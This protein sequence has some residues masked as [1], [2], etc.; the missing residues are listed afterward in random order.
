MQKVNGEPSSAG[1]LH[2]QKSDQHQGEDDP[3]CKEDNAYSPLSKGH[4]YLDTKDSEKC[5]GL[6]HTVGELACSFNSRLLE[7]NPAE[8]RFE[9]TVVNIETRVFRKLQL[10][11]PKTRLFGNKS[12]DAG[13]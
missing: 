4:I 10:N 8:R 5:S 9:L 6:T 12:L 11:L 1:V 3:T 13:H 2:S 7:N